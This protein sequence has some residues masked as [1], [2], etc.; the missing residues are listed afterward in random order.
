MLITIFIVLPN[1]ITHTGCAE[2]N[3]HAY[4]IYATE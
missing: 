4:T 1:R 3:R 2:M